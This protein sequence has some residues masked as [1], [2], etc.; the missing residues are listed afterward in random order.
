MQVSEARPCSKA[1]NGGNGSVHECMG[2]LAIMEE[3]PKNC[4]NFNT[5][6]VLPG[7]S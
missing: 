2:R 7:F 4:R 1:N 6:Y 3:N 5:N